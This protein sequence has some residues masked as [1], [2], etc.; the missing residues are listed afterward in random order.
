M[1]EECY[2]SVEHLSFHESRE[3]Y[4]TINICSHDKSG[5]ITSSGSWH[6]DKCEYS[7]WEGCETG[8]PRQAQ[9][10]VQPG[11]NQWLATEDSRSITHTW[12]NHGVDSP[13]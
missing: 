10:T 9:P 8:T 5:S 11:L 6:V 4:M 2:A 3:G 1:Q 13:F 7:P 12:D